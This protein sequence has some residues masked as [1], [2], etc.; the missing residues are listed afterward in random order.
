CPGRA[1]RL[2]LAQYLTVRDSLLAMLRAGIEARNFGELFA[3]SQ[4][5]ARSKEGLENLIEVLYSL[6]QDILH[7]E[8]RA[9]GEPLRNADRPK[10]LHEI[11]RTLGVDKVAEAAAALGSLERNLRRN[12]P[13]QISLEA[14]AVSLGP[15][16]RT[17]ER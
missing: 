15:G 9:D 12:V 5:L 17:P 4:K 16:R 14:F 3:E 2:D 13:A 8:T 7:L 10:M 11:A 6:L 1:L